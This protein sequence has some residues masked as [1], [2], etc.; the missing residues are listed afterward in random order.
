MHFVDLTKGGVPLP[1]TVPAVLVPPAARARTLSQVPFPHFQ[2]WQW[3]A[4]G[5]LRRV[6]GAAKVH[7]ALGRTWKVAVTVLQGEAPEISF[8]FEMELPQDPMHKVRNISWPWS[9]NP[10][11]DHTSGREH[12]VVVCLQSGEAGIPTPPVPGGL[13]MT[14]DKAGPS[15]PYLFA[16]VVMWREMGRWRGPRRRRPSWPPLSKSAGGRTWR[17]ARRSWRSAGPCSR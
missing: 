3:A 9:H 13:P 15:S 4:G 17:R 10:Y 5:W 6:P 2:Q 14:A 16:Q 11:H 12:A 8:A 7:L 1:S